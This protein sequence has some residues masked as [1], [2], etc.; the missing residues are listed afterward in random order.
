M[1]QAAAEKGVAEEIGALRL[2]LA[3]VA[4]ASGRVVARQKE[5]TGGDTSE[6]Q[7]ARFR[8]LAEPDAA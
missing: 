2:M 5:L 8:A 4:G 1:A 7:T 3:R 6:F